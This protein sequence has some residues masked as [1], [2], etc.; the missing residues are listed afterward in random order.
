MRTLEVVRLIE[1]EVLEHVTFHS[2]VSWHSKKQNSV[3]LSKEEAEYIVVGLVCAQVLW[4][5][6]TL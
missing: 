5:K 6:Q 2:L 1:K 4:M 3:V